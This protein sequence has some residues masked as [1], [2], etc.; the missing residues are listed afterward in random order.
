MSTTYSSRLRLAIQATG[1]NANSW[2]TILNSNTIAL[3][4][5]A[6]T[7]MATI[8]LSIGSGNYTLSTAN[9]TADEAR[10]A[11]LKF[12]GAAT[13][14]RTVIIP[15]LT[16]PYFV[17]NAL[18]T[19]FTVTISTGSGSTVVLTQGQA[20]CVYCDGTNVYQMAPTNV[21][22]IAN[23]LSDLNNVATA[24]TNLGLGTAATTAATAYATAAQG[25]KAD[26]ALQSMVLTKLTS[27]SGTYTTPAN[28][29][30]IRIKM[31]GAGG[32]GGA[33]TN[34]NGADGNATSFGSLTAN[35]GLG[36]SN[37]TSF[38]AGTGTVGGG[39]S[40]GS[41]TA[42]IRI[43]GNSGLAAVTFGAPG[44][45]G[46]LGGS[47]SASTGTGGAAA[48]NSGAGGGGGAS[49]VS[50]V[51]GGCG[52]GSGEYVENLYTAP[53]ATYS[54]S[55]G[56]KGIGGIPGGNGG[57]DGGSGFIIIEEYYKV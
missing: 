5:A 9:G 12:T 28:V 36:G 54:Y 38:N 48:L 1:E 22:L 19:N 13:T 27:G 6:I 11:I 52:G 30:F 53:A 57:G 8:D 34:N 55:I 2:G 4:E 43:S 32:G 20:I 15:S 49:N 7:E 50:N 14:S 56:A 44:A 24:R 29:K 18:S 45:P 37:G 17:H 40:G 10:K 51:P 25:T 41:G 23:N 31:W 46:P 16:K 21:L 3:V 26:S 47:G 42:D 33:R 35:P 39:G